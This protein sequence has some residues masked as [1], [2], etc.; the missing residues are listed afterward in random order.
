MPSTSTGRP[1]PDDVVEAARRARRLVGAV[2]SPADSLGSCEEWATALGELRALADVVEAAEAEVAVRLAAIEPLVLETGELV[3]T[4]R[5]PGHVSLDAPSI[6]SGV[7]G[8]TAV[9]A[10]RWVRDAVRRVADGPE[11]TGTETGLGALHLAMAQGRL[12]GYRAGVVAHELEEVPAQV[13]STVLEAV[14]AYLGVEDAPRLRRRVRRVLARISPDLLR[15][16]AVRARAAS[17]LR[18]WVDE[19]G[20]D[21]WLGTFPSEEACRAWATIDALAQRLVADGSCEGIDRA[22]ARALTDLVTGSAT[23]DLRVHVVTVVPGGAPDDEV[24][25]A[26]SAADRRPDDLVAVHGAAPGEPVL[27]ARDW[28]ERAVAATSSRADHLGRVVVDSSSGAL[29]P[30]GDTGADAYRP[31]AVLVR[32]VR[33]RDGRCRFPGCH[34]AARFCDLDHVVAWP[35]G[36]TA[37]SNLVCLCRRHHRTKQRPG[38]AVTLHPDATTTWV[39][40]AGRRRTTEPLDHRPVVLPDTGLDADPPPRPPGAAPSDARHSALEHRLEHGGP[41]QPSRGCGVEIHRPRGR[42]P[43]PL[44]VDLAPHHRR[45][46]STPPASPPF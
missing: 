24:R 41:P 32:L 45:R 46:R 39:D 15:Q 31:G 44:V 22:R 28:L 3:E 40:P 25:P 16:R 13:A 38:W 30:V 23:I 1:G 35:A 12:D 8:M 4:H 43:R 19:P 37:A 9:H 20:T 33:A 10:E 6:V 14:D 2:L 17:S 26:R 34:V 27:V 5:A 36:P 42:P 18:R 21:T 11:G 7:L 29:V